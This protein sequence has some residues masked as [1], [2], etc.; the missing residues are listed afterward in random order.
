MQLK[1][2]YSLLLLC[3]ILFAFTSCG[4]ST[5]IMKTPET[6]EEA[7]KMLL[8]KQKKEA[9]AGR[10]EAKARQKHYWS[11]Q[12]A[13]VKKSIKRNEKRNKQNKKKRKRFIA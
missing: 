1:T 7:E 11:I 5:K 3:G 13:D 9:K 8:K 2:L 12:S 6:T 4:S 10:A